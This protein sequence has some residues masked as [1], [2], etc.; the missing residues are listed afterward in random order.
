M[1][2]NSWTFL[3]FLVAVFLPYYFGPRWLSGTTTGQISL[4]TVASF[5]FYGWASPWLV[6]LLMVSTA[7]NAEAARRMLLPNAAPAARKR[8]LVA[9]LCFNLGALGLFKYAGLFAQMLLPASLWARWGGTLGS[10][11]LPIGISFYTF[12]GISLVMDIYRGGAAGVPGIGDVTGRHGAWWLHLRVW[13]FKA[14]FPQLIAGPIVKAHEFIHQ[15]GLKRFRDLPW[16]TAVKH[17][18]AGFFL[19]MVVADNLKEATNLIAYPAFVGAPAVNLIAALYGFSFQI[20][21]DFAGYSLIALGLA[22]LFGYRL[23]PNFYWPYLSASIT[24]FWRRWH[25][26]LSSWLRQYLY[27]PLG[28]NRLGSGRT[29]VNLFIVMFL[30]GLWHGAA[31]SYAIW[32]SAH[33]IL[34][35]LERLCGVQAPDPTGPI[36]WNFLRAV[37]VFVIFSVVSL[38]WLLFKLPDIR[39]VGIYLQ[40][41]ATLRGGAY[42]QPLF[43]LGLFGLPVVLLHMV[44]ASDGLRRRLF[45]DV[46]EARWVWVESAL[47]AGMLFLI[48]V[49][50]GTAGEFIYF[51]F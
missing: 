39:H 38:L 13:F 41:I 31:W 2:F 30:G 12:Q 5:V 49:N 14:F 3:V 8:A 44:M 24:E 34:L 50:A 27:I 4:L 9:A 21:A 37:R 42:P 26:S 35:A 25:V 7:I 48:L 40:E 10:I 36:R 45:A 20:F 23:V 43:V 6:P 19:K 47:Y 15:I 51:Q 33:G 28:G 32:G 22:E 1:L 18:I 46:R 16:D 11:P 17:L 29:Y